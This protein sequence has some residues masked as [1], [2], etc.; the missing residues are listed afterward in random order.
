MIVLRRGGAERTGKLGT[1]SGADSKIVPAAVP[2]EAE[3]LR[4]P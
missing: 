1:E 3:A 2:G 4:K